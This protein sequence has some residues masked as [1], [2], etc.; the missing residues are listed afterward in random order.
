MPDW[1]RIIVGDAFKVPSHDFNYY[2]DLFLIWP[3][4]LCSV[5]GISQLYAPV[6]PAGRISGFKLAAC[7]AFLLLLAKEKRLLILVTC[8][9]LGF[10]VAIRLVLGLLLLRHDWKPYLLALLVSSGAALVVL[11]SSKGWRPSYTRNSTGKTYMLDLV[12]VVISLGGTIAILSWI[13][14]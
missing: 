6:S 12:V 14:P 13:K 9:Y 8:F 4:M 11:R 5:A 2:R 1:K 7:A 10:R 3:F